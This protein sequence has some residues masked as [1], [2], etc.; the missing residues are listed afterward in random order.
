MNTDYG[1]LLNEQ[2][3]KYQRRQFN[4]MVRLYGVYVKY[5]DISNK[6]FN[7]YSEIVGD[8]N[9]WIRIGVI[10]TDHIDQRTQKKLGWNSELVENALV[11]NFPYDT[12]NIQVG[13]LI[14]VPSGIDNA[15]P[16]MFRI[17]RMSTI[18]IYPSSI[19]CECVPEMF[20]SL[21]ASYTEDFRNSSMHVLLKD[22]DDNL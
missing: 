4:E 1:L 16:R 6:Q 7:N 14:Q 5:Y 18:M 8:I 13:C 22:E 20:N 3:I 11:V 15:P 10:F 21:P 17:S 12:P 2:N 9:N 19:T